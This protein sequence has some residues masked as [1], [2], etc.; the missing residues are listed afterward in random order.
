MGWP[1]LPPPKCAAWHH[2]EIPGSRHGWA[3]EDRT[4]STRGA[5]EVDNVAGHSRAGSRSLCIRYRGLTAGRWARVSTPIFPSDSTQPAGYAIPG[6]PRLYSGQR[7]QAAGVAGATPRPPVELRVFA[8]VL[9]SESREPER[10]VHGRPVRLRPATAFTASLEIPD[11]G[12]WPV[13]DLGLEIRGSGGATGEIFL[14]SVRKQGRPQ[15]ARFDHVPLTADHRPVG[16]ITDADAVRCLRHGEHAFT[17]VR[18]NEGCAVLVTGADDWTDY[19]FEGEMQV[20]LAEQAGLLVRYQGL[21]RYMALVQTRT[22]LRLALTWY[23]QSVLAEVRRR[24]VVDRPQ[25]LRLTC[26]GR[27]VTAACDGRVLLQA[28]DRR[29]GH[30]GAGFLVDTGTASFRSAHLI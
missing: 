14:D 29:L 8:R 26:K 19:T 23:G 22:H 2:F 9:D 10:L 17:T 27:R 18:R 30:G 1:A 28:E 5:A 15:L 12:G 21:R 16:W 20:H 7:V 4:L 11:T 3:P 24:W 25:V 13:A 6:T